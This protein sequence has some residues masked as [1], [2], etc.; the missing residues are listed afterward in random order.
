MQKGE[1][2]SN[3]LSNVSA[4]EKLAIL[5]NIRFLDLQINVLK[6]FFW[7]KV[8]NLICIYY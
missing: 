7:K 4:M 6:T 2:T 3:F 5:H 1:K 8:D